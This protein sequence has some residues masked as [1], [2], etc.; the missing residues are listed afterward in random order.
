M[1]SGE[2]DDTLSARSARLTTATANIERVNRTTHQAQAWYHRLS[3]WY[4]T[5]A[6]PFEA[7]A[8]ATGIRCLDA[9]PG[10]CV[11]DV[12]CGTGTALVEF[13]RAVGSDGRAY[14]ID[15][16]PGMCDE[17]RSKLTAAGLEQTAVLLGD[18]LELPLRDDSLDALFA[19]FVLELFDSPD[20]PRVLAEWRR[21]LGRDGRVCVVALSRREDRLPVRLYEW[22]HRRFPRLAD[23]RPI[24][25][26]ATL[27][28]AGFEVHRRIE[29]SVGGL[30]VEVVVAG[31]GGSRGTQVR[32]RDRSGG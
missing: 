4:D 25:T 13:G 21:V 16:A 9:Q 12:G 28:T 2:Y 22:V 6:D 29:R 14:G 8:R 23:C 7:D 3:G 31:L 1:R 10:E 27:E 30:P 15:I 26:A 32:T 20:I 17:S 18:A 5:F 24:Y 19:S 11:L